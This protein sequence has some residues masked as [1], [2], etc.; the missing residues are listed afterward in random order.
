MISSARRK[1]LI[2]YTVTGR[3]LHVR[4]DRPAELL[5]MIDRDGDGCLMAVFHQFK[6]PVHLWGDCLGVMYISFS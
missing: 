2:A 6:F 4:W 1:D 3:H 5:L